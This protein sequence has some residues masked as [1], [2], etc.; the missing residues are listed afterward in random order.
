M[1]IMTPMT[2]LEAVNEMLMSIGQAPVNSLAVTGITDVSTA[3]ARLDTAVRNLLAQ[4]YWFNTDKGFALQPDADGHIPVPADALRITSD[5]AAVAERVHP[6]KGRALYDTDSNTFVFAASVTCTI[7]RAMPFDHMPQTARAYA[8]TIAAR[9][10][11]SKLIG[12][13]ILDHFEQEDEAKAWTMLLREERV[14]RRTNMFSN[15]FLA[16]FGDRSH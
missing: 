14:A 7:I 4:G 2:E 15:P 3:K 6:T 5:D 10:F 9:R 12:S 16:G 13:Q 8:A 11:Q 1:S